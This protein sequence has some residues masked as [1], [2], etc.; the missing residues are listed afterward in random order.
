MDR[1]SL[2]PPPDLRFG[3]YL[4]YIR[5]LEAASIARELK[6]NVSSRAAAAVQA[7]VMPSYDGALELFGKLTELIVDKQRE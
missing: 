4:S 5:F 2:S 7:G 6:A 3:Y 1:V